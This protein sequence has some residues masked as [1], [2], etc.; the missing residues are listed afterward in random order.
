MNYHQR[1]KKFNLY[2]MAQRRERFTIIY[3]WQMLEGIQTDVLGL[4]M[5]LSEIS[6]HRSI[7]LGGLK[8]YRLDRTR[9]L[10]SIQTKI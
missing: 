5:K 9:M 6:Y 1:R 10:G 4:Q 7:K 2:S 8:Q 3:A